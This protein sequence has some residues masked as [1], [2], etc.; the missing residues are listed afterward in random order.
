MLVY[1]PINRTRPASPENTCQSDRVLNAPLMSEPPCAQGFIPS[2]L[3]APAIGVKYL[4]QDFYPWHNWKHTCGYRCVL[5][6]AHI[7][8]HEAPHWTCSSHYPNFNAHNQ[9]IRVTHQAERSIRDKGLGRLKA[10]G[11]KLLHEV[12]R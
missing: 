4:R 10:R 7:V 8:T 12:T 5:F 11:V 3:P 6:T 1:D 9:A 2:L